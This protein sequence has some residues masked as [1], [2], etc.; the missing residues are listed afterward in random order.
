MARPVLFG[1][2]PLLTDESRIV[3]TFKLKHGYVCLWSSISSQ[4]RVWILAVRTLRACGR[5]IH[6]SGGRTRLEESFPS[7]LGSR[8]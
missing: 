1:S 2:Q 7:A 5:T 8:V 6:L 3:T 4:C